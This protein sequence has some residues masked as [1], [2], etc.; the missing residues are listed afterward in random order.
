MP[1]FTVTFDKQD[2]HTLQNFYML[3]KKIF[4]V[5]GTNRYN[6]PAI[7]GSPRWSTRYYGIS[8]HKAYFHYQN[9]IIETIFM[10]S[11]TYSVNVAAQRYINIQKS[12]NN[13]YGQFENKN[14]WT[15]TIF[16]GDTRYLLTALQAGHLKLIS[17]KTVGKYTIMHILYYNNYKPQ[18]TIHYMDTQRKI[19]YHEYEE[20]KN[21]N[22][23]H[24][25]NN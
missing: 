24:A 7:S 3:D 20:R 12:L 21:S 5:P 23:G 16:K 2:N 14:Q 6:D 11:T 15:N 8:G 4:K 17:T 13:K 19:E 1:E 10:L 22:A 9:R 18:H 25:A